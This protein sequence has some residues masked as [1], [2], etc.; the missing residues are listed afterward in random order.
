M[1]VTLHESFDIESPAL[2]ESERSTNN[3]HCVH[4][5]KVEK[6]ALKLN[7]QKKASLFFIIIIIIIDLF[8]VGCYL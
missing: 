4:V 5:I 6:V 2:S 1:D 3:D 7:C 8:N